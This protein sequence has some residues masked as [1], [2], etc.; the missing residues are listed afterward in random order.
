MSGFVVNST[1]YK[2]VSRAQKT[3]LIRAVKLVRHVGDLK[4]GA[5]WVHKADADEY[6]RSLSAFDDEDSHATPSSTVVDSQPSATL[7]A[8]ASLASIDT[9]LDEIYRVLE[10]LASAVENIATQPKTAQQELMHT[11]S[12]N[13]FHS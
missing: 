3:G 2:A 9:T 5:V 7:A 6:L 10:R 4:G 12:S 11:F 13:G 1:D 8:A